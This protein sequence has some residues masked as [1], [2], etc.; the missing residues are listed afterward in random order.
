MDNKV[1]KVYGKKERAMITQ[2]RH[3]RTDKSHQQKSKKY[4]TEEP[5]SESVSDDKSGNAD[6]VS[7]PDDE[8]GNV[9]T[10]DDESGNAD[11]ES[12]SDDSDSDSNFIPKHYFSKDK[13]PHDLREALRL[14]V[15]WQLSRFPDEDK[16]DL[17]KTFEQQLDHVN[18]IIIPAIMESLNKTIFPVTNA[19]VYSM[20]HSLHQHRR[21]K[22]KLKERSPEYI[23]KQ[24]RRRHANSRRNSKQKNRAKM[25]NHL[26]VV[27]DPLIRKFNDERL[28]PV[29]NNSAYHS[30]EIS[31]TDEENPSG[32]RKI[33]IRNLKWRSSTEEEKPCNAPKWTC[34]KYKGILKTYVNDACGRRFGNELP[35]RPNELNLMHPYNYSDDENLIP[36]CD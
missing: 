3:S 10:S 26:R 21:E 15:K 13:M 24:C 29:I 33:V 18:E 5:D 6:N 25:I 2:G 19:V 16:L 8:S 9:S 31:E 30:P 34:T 7:T 27:G 35:S 12:T 22:Y 32:K 20:I 28:Q 36:Q 1:K 11:S 23:D 14:E 17:N 4:S